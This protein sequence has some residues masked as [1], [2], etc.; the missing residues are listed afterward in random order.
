M[1]DN[2]KV[3]N[4]WPVNAGLAV[5]VEDNA[6]NVEEGACLTRGLSRREVLLTL[7]LLSSTAQRSGVDL[8]SRQEELLSFNTT[9]KHSKNSSLINEKAD[10]KH[11]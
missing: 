9:R 6:A 5:D 4:T 11:G 1:I 7:F 10:T 2:K 3:W 8:T